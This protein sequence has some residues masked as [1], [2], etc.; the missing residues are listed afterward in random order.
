M[1]RVSVSRQRPRR[2][3]KKYIS[4][5]VGESV[6]SRKHAIAHTLSSPPF[7]PPLSFFAGHWYPWDA[8]NAC[9]IEQRDKVWVTLGRACLF[10][11][12]LL[13]AIDV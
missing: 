8:I 11:L 9:R 4:L 12:R 10:V 13:L 1:P 5:S 3:K 2:L 6:I 7:P